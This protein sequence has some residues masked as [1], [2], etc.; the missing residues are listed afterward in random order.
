MKTILRATVALL[1]SLFAGGCATQRTITP[2]AVVT[3]QRSTMIAI[4]RTKDAVVIGR[5]TKADVRARLGETQVISFDN[6]FEIWVYRLP[7]EMPATGAASRRTA[8]SG[9]EEGS[10]DRRGE[11]VILFAPS[12]LV[13]KTRIRPAPMVL[14][15]G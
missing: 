8:R 15:R 3:P 7:G 14:P 9:S 12:G 4:E 11:F 5:S 6:G 2:S 1:F 10:S 13:A